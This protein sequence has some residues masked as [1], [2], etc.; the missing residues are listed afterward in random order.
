MDAADLGFFGALIM[1][2]QRLA[3]DLRLMTPA[4]GLHLGVELPDDW[5]AQLDTGAW[6]VSGPANP[7]NGHALIV[8]GYDAQGAKLA[9]WGQIVPATWAWISRYVTEAYVL[10][11]AGRLAVDV[12]D[13]AQLAADVV[14]LGGAS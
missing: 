7:D 4:V 11:D 1:L 3:V 5:Q 10:L 13:G 2:G 6:D 12:L 14:A 9:T 8:A